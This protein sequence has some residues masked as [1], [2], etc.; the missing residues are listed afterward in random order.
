MSIIYRST[1]SRSD[2]DKYIYFRLGK[3]CDLRCLASA[4]WR[5]ILG[6]IFCQSTPQI[7]GCVILHK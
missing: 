7:L 2:L 6:R 5:P 3:L 1:D 4:G